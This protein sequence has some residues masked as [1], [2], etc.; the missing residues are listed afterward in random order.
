[1]IDDYNYRMG[2]VGV[3]DQLRLLYRAQRWMCQRNAG[4]QFFCSASV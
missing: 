3:A 2:G 1:M 4:G